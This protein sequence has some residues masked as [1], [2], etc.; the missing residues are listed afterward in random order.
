MRAAVAGGQARLDGAGVGSGARLW[1]GPQHLFSRARRVA[2]EAVQRG[3][4]PDGAHG[5]DVRVAHTTGLQ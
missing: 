3:G 2:G 1:A 4:P 5:A